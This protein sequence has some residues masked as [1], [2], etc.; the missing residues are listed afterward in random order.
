MRDGFEAGW[1]ERLVVVVQKDVQVLL[2]H[3]QKIFRLDEACC[4][5]AGKLVGV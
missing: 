2:L 4:I 3:H 5:D 1:E